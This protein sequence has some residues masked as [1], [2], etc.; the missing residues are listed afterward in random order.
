MRAY[1][2]KRDNSGIS[3]ITREENL[4]QI[5]LIIAETLYFIKYDLDLH[6]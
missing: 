4:V 2:H 5:G 3:V 6:F 1:T